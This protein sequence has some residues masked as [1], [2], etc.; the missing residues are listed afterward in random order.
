MTRVAVGMSGGIDSTVTAL[1][2]IKQGFEVIGATMAIWDES[3][4]ITQ[5]LKSG[6]F[7]PGERD[8][9]EAA[10]AVCAKLGIEHRV[11]ALKEEFGS[12]V[13]SYFCGT[14]AQGK[15]PNPCVVCNQRLKFGILP[16]K[17]REAGVEFDF[18]AT[19]HYV[20]RC[21]SEALQRWQ[22]KR[23]LDKEKDQSY[24]LCF[25]AQEQLANT[26]FPLGELGKAEVRQ[27]A[28]SKGF[29]ELAQKKES[30]DF[31]E[32]DNYSVL[33]E[34]DTFRE[35]DIIDPR[36]KVIGR[37][38]GL[39]HYTIGQRRNL[40][41]SGQSEPVYVLRIDALRNQLVVGPKALLYRNRLSA[42][43]VNWLSIPAPTE[44]SSCL[45]RIRYQ[46]EAAACV[47]TPVPNGTYQVV[48]EEPQLAITPGQ[49]VVFYDGDLLLGGG[50]IQ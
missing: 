26:L 40:G 24:F 8:D 17:L 14:Y 11:V 27:I 38:R 50:V 28:R 18:F 37:H 41:I 31:L 49:I 9:L 7:G 1:I 30:Q 47:V 5:S 12:N 25:L 20:R 21:F 35:G 15:T 2:L 19:G 43:Q 23:A 29:P 32:T 44:A 33:F 16:Q 3:I 48:F 13:L 42:A 6:C 22:L 46:H 36:G 45:A 4:P 10:R 34:P 39:I